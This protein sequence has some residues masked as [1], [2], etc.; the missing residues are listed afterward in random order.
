[1]IKDKV[2]SDTGSGDMIPSMDDFTN[3]KPMMVIT[4]DTISPEIYSMRPIPKGC[5]LLAGRLA[6]LNP[7]KVTIDDAASERLFA[8]SAMMEIDADDKPIMNFN[9]QSITLHIIPTIPLRVPYLARTCFFVRVFF[10][11]MK[12]YIKSLEI[13]IVTSYLHSI[14]QVLAFFEYAAHYFL[15]VV[16][17]S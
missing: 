3:S 4:I 7:T 11:K 5:L 9:T 13:K 10:F 2:L 17:M 16:W 12:L 1:M 14:L 6:S 15:Y 8:A